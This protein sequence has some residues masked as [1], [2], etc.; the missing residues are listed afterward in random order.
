MICKVG[1]C[2]RLERNKKLQKNVYY[3]NKYVFHLSNPI[4]FV[5]EEDDKK[6]N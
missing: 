4:K 2:N 6:K 3:N 1:V 5:E